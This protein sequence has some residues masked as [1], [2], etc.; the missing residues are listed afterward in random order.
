VADGDERLD[1]SGAD[2]HE[3]DG[4]ASRH[5]AGGRATSAPVVTAARARTAAPAGESASQGSRTTWTSG[6]FLVASPC[7]GGC[8]SGSH[9]LLTLRNGLVAGEPRGCRA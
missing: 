2:G 7:G 5:D 8:G 4:K 1:G 9:R 3:F 6:N